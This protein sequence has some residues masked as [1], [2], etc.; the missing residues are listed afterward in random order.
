MSYR[1]DLL[2]P[3]DLFFA[4]TVALKHFQSVWTETVY[5]VVDCF[6][7]SSYVIEQGVPKRGVKMDQS[8][9]LQLNCS[10]GHL[11]K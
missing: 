5:K 10:R 1:F 9:Y 3:R 4:V 2:E 11:G 8:E 6:D 7:C